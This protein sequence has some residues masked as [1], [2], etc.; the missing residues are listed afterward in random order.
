MAKVGDLFLIEIAEVFKGAESGAT[1]Y[2]IKGFD[3][4]IFDENGIDKL[5]EFNI[6]DLSDF[7]Y[8]RIKKDIRLGE[9][10]AYRVGYERGLKA[11]KNESIDE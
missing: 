7:L 11:Q 5:D 3:N 9:A 10:E 1:K 2:R 8:K 6:S 4:L